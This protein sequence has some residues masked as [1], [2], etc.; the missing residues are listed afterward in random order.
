MTFEIVTLPDFANWLKNIKDG[1]TKQRL[2]RR[3]ERV[4]NGNFGDHH[5]VGDGVNELR[6]HF[7]QGWRM[8][9]V[10]SGNT[11]IVMLGGG[12][13][14]TQTA[15]IKQVKALFDKLAFRD[16]RP[17]VSPNED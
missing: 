12:V 4:A 5:S 13:K 1:K 11:I 6:E 10:Q 3:L 7:G 2:I 15:N 8:Y 17:V 16:G 14:S 9:Y